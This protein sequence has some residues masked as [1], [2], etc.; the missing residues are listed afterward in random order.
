MALLKANV[1]DG[2]WHSAR[3]HRIGQWVQL[4]LDSG[5]GINF[6]Q[7]F[8][9]PGG[10]LQIHVSQRSLFAGGE[11]RFPSSRGPPLVDYDFENSKHSGFSLFVMS[12]LLV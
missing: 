1:S 8:G 6:N 3:V 9:I 2:V 10:H 7:S 4:Q 12:C 11:A 5:E